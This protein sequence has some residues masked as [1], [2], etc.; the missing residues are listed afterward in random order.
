MIR[1]FFK[2]FKNK[3]VFFIISIFFILSMT[4]FLNFYF[5]DKLNNEY[6]N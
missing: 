5:S 1:E 3:L 4:N 2:S 6:D